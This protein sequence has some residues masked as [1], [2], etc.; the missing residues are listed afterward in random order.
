[1]FLECPKITDIWRQVELCLTSKN[2]DAIKISDT[3]II[4][5]N[6][7]CVILLSTVIMAIKKKI[8]QC[9][10]KN[11]DV[12]LDKVEFNSWCLINAKPL[13]SITLDIQD[14]RE[15]IWE[16]YPSG[17]WTYTVWVGPCTKR[18]AFGL[19]LV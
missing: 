5:C 11:K 4:I 2:N 6:D 3:E 19:R 14:Y 10:L 16:A 17:H 13:C 12:H 8:H 7:D 15:L 1:M 18:R 9:R